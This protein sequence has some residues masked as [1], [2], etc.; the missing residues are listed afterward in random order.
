MIKLTRR[1][2]GEQMTWQYTEYSRILF[3]HCFMLSSFIRSTTIA[4]EMSSSVHIGYLQAPRHDHQPRITE[5]QT[6]AM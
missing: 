3:P 6:V 5:V 4:T 2:R 1:Y